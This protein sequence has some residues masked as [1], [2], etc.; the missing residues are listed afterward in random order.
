LVAA[1]AVRIIR[2]LSAGQHHH[3]V[4]LVLGQT[5]VVAAGQVKHR[6]IYPLIGRQLQP[7]QLPHLPDMET[8]EELTNSLAV[9]AIEVALVVGVQVRKV[10]RWMFVAR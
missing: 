2:M 5:A 9:V 1:A 7:P 4:F 8:Q 10:D 3:P 6:R